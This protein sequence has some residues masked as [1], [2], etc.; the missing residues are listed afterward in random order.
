MSLSEFARENI[1]EPLGMTSTR[2]VDTY[3]ETV[4]NRASGYRRL[5]APGQGFEKRM[6]NYDLTGPTNL[7]TTV[8]DLML[9]DANFD[10]RDPPWEA[11]TP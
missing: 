3:R 5:K 7:F 9:W 4:K 8:E 2:F 11:R 1:F 10:K 6:P